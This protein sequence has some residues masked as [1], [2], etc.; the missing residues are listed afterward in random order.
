[1]DDVVLSINNSIKTRT[2]ERQR[3]YGESN[4]AITMLKA[5]TAELDRKK[6]D[7]E[8]KAKQADEAISA[9]SKA[10]SSGKSKAIQKCETKE[11]R[12]MNALSVSEEVYEYQLRL[13]NE[14]IFEIYNDSLVSNLKKFEEF[15][16][17]GIN[18]YGL[19]SKQI[20]ELFKR[21]PKQMKKSAEMM[22]NAI[23]GFD[24]SQSVDDFVKKNGTALSLP[25]PLTFEV[26][27]ATSSTFPS[28]TPKEQTLF[29]FTNP[30]FSGIAYTTAPAPLPVDNSAKSSPAPKKKKEVPF[31]SSFE[32]TK[33]STPLARHT[34]AVKSIPIV[35][36]DDGVPLD[37]DSDDGVPIDNDDSDDGVP[38]DDDDDG[39]P[40]G[41]SVSAPTAMQ[42][43]PV[44]TLVKEPERPPS[45]PLRSSGIALD[46]SNSSPS[47]ANAGG[48][49]LEKQ[50]TP[51][52]SRITLEKS[53]PPPSSSNIGISKTSS[54]PAITS[55]AGDGATIRN[56]KPSERRRNM[57]SS[58]SSGSKAGTMRPQKK[59][60]GTSRTSNFN[61]VSSK[62]LS[63]MENMG[64][65]GQMQVPAG[66][67]YFMQ[68]Q[69]MM[70]TNPEY[71]QMMAQQFAQNPQL[72]QQYQ[73]QMVQYQQML[74]AQQMQASGGVQPV[75]GGQPVLNGQPTDSAPSPPSDQNTV[76]LSKGDTSTLKT[77][78]P[79]ASRRANRPKS[80]RDKLASQLDQSQLHDGTI[81]VP[82]A[83]DVSSVVSQLGMTTL[84]MTDSQRDALR[85]QFGGGVDF[86]LSGL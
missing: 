26:F 35:D 67:E 33:S 12:C 40:I 57:A 81:R 74:Y 58:S 85:A 6:K 13:T 62:K 27:A 79:R 72:Y 86:D 24:V 7:Y 15:K 4:A 1:M 16:K 2:V 10:R 56:I 55:D 77:S 3:I 82:S 36:D 14:R 52:S 54:A 50:P 59:S 41:A 32:E 22:V 34:P 20:T 39:V 61:S 37:D 28:Y 18:E 44:I 29:N 83:E 76:K 9:L 84:S 48:I 38:I 78:N 8:A 63:T 71:R 53:S 47:R 5:A 43:K 23:Q 42:F 51:P 60:R 68:Q 66:M 25:T 75:L 17:A 31:S 64:H 70:M 49:T 80:S 21:L 73:M 65:P 30:A 45:S 46:K 11:E 19:L 69:Q